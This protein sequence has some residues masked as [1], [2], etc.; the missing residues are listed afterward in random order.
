MAVDRSLEGIVATKRSL[1]DDVVMDH[2]RNAR[3]YRAIPGA[4]HVAEGINPLCGDTF[5]L[6]VRVEGG[7]V[8]EAAFQCECCGISM[9]SASIMTELVTD[10]N[11]EEALAL[12]R[13]FDLL[14]NA[15]AQ[16]EGSRLSGSALAILDLI[17]ES[18]SR[19]N[20]ARLSWATLEAALDGRSQAVVGG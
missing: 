19:M 18:P 15:Q 10:R 8:R 6:Y 17:R 7:L 4:S 16:P 3:N 1:Y 14:V 20:C 9:A 13:E 12:A 11:V 5:S 2:I